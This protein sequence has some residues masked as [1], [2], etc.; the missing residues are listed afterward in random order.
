MPFGLNS[1]NEIFQKS[2]CRLFK[3]LPGLIIMFDD[4]LLHAKDVQ[5]H[6]ER[7]DILLNKCREVGVKLNRKKCSFLVS[8]I[9]YIRHIITKNGI[10]P[11]PEK[12][13]AI[14]QMPKPEDKK[15][16]Q[17][18]LGMVTY[19]GRYIP[20]LSS[21]HN[22]TAHQRLKGLMF[23]SSKPSRTAG[24]TWTSP[25]SSYQI[26]LPATMETKTAFY[27]TSTINWSLKT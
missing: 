13:D 7:L 10:K 15:G 5:E 2:M 20:N 17:R 8:E 14:L 9:K 24:I 1:A 21:Q 16:A 19:I 3:D 4:I 26:F 18:L 23:L 6:N 22:N 11:D 12:I 27:P 25:T